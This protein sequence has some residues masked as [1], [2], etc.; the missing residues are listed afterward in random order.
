MSRQQRDAL[1]SDDDDEARRQGNSWLK[2]QVAEY[3]NPARLEK[4]VKNGN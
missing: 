3:I 1:G 2:S 4:C